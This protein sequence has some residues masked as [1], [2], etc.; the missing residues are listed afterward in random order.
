MLKKVLFGAAVAVAA[1]AIT[2]S[3]TAAGNPNA[4]VLPTQS[5]C[6]GATYAEWS[7]RWWQWAHLSPLGSDPVSDT[8]GQFAASGQ[9]GHVWFLAG[10]Y[11]AT[12]VVRNVT[13]PTGTPLFFPVLNTEWETWPAFT[14]A[15]FPPTGYLGDPPFTVPGAEQAARDAIA[16]FIDAANLLS[17]QVDG[18]SLNV[19]SNYRVKSTVFSETLPA[20]NPFGIPAGAYHDC[21][22][23]GYW[24]MLTPLSK[25]SHTIHI[26]GGTTGF[27]TE[28]TYHLTVK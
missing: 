6:F 21:V 2:L 19:A 4:G 3:A 22:S 9:S 27:E 26:D 8:T 12:G 28:A 23:D 10:T 24:I 15:Q 5:S 14:P 20:G 11:G 7:A 1:G 16:P 25:G 13:I 17:V 18:T